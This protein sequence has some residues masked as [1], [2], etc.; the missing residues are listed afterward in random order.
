MGVLEVSD[1]RSGHVCART[2]RFMIIGGVSCRIYTEREKCDRELF[3]VGC[4][5]IVRSRPIDLTLKRG[6][7]IE[8]GQT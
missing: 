5:V 3:H 7:V 2:L 1:R 6:T 8:D 4:R